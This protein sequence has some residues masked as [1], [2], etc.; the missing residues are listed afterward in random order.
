MLWLLALWRGVVSDEGGAGGKVLVVHNVQHFE[1]THGEMLRALRRHFGQVDSFKSSEVLS[2]R[3]KLYG[4]KKPLYDLVVMVLPTS[5]KAMPVAEKLELLQ[6]YDEGKSLMLLGDGFSVQSWRI[7]LSQFGFDAVTAGSEGTGDNR[8]FTSTLDSR[9]FVP[10]SAFKFEKL[11]AGIKKGIVYD[12]GALSLSPYENVISWSLMEAPETALLIRENQPT[13]VIDRNMM[14]LVVAAQGTNNRARVVGVGSFRMFSNELN[15]ESEGDNLQYFENLVK[16]LKFETHVFTIENLTVC[17]AEDLRCPSPATF[18]KK[19]Q[20]AVRFQVFDEDGNFY[21][22]AEGKIYTHLTK[23]TPIATT[24]LKPVTENGEQFYSEVLNPLDKG[25]YKLTI[26]H[27]KPGYYF[28]SRENIRMI[29]I[30]PDIIEHIELFSLEGLPFLVIIGLVMFS[31]L[32]TL[33]VLI[34]NKKHDK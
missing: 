8:L 31:A 3:V 10:K 11:A 32:N 24:E 21:A 17:S 5:G 18:R 19:Y 30:L 27:N 13:Q 9:I 34:N 14:N 26:V 1:L 6:F 20:V 15:N 16:W 33:R 23:Q 25:I 22:P 29:N 2:S 12:G 7:L 28:D 4:F